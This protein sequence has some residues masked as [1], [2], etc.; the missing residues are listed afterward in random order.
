MFSMAIPVIPFDV[1]NSK[2]CYTILLN[3]FIVVF[4]DRL[5]DNT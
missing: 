1:L 4:T 2:T 3:P 5:H